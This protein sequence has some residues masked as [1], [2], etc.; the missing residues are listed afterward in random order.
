MGGK[1]K[2]RK[3]LLVLSISATFIHCTT[4]P[5]ANFKDR[6]VIV[7]AI[8]VINNDSNFAF[9]DKIF[10]NE[11][12]IKIRSIDQNQIV[13]LKSNN[14]GLFFS[15]SLGEGIYE[16]V[17]LKFSKRNYS[18]RTI[19]NVLTPEN[20][21]KY[22][23]I[24]PNK[25]NNI[26]LIIW[27]MEDRNWTVGYSTNFDEVR[28]EFEKTKKYNDYLT[29]EWINI[30]V[31]LLNALENR[32]EIFNYEYEF[33]V[34]RDDKYRFFELWIIWNKLANEYINIY[35]IPERN[36]NAVEYINANLKLIPQTIFDTLE[37]TLTIS[38]DENEVKKM[39]LTP[40]EEEGWI[41]GID[42]TQK[43]PSIMK[44]D[45]RNLNDFIC[46]NYIYSDTEEK[47]SIVF[48]W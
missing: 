24:R 21:Y 40:E 23:F 43:Y 31:P 27:T 39:N 10:Y 47:E 22:F 45:G 26:G 3:L 15:E 19:H 34:N 35:P 6:T 33:N 32:R 7:G 1:M 29:Y 44:D 13:E 46:F 20:G 8:Y 16:I 14:D 30:G 28:N 18:T 2:Y 5:G 36:M 41:K 4:V 38:I 11:I 17:E 37:W 42:L 12:V 25:I 9:L 48:G